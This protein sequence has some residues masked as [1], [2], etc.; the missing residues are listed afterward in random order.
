YGYT[1]FDA[2]GVFNV[3][4]FKSFSAVLE[5]LT[6]DRQKY[7]GAKQNQQECAREWGILDGNSQKRIVN[8]INKLVQSESVI[9]IENKNYDLNILKN[10][11]V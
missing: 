1:D 2:K 5:E 9:D 10:S 7:E 6:R 11:D 3:N 4:D 8:L